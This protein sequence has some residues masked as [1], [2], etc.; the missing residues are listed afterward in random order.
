MIKR[1]YI[2]RKFY[3]NPNIDF[4]RLNKLCNGKNYLI[5]DPGIKNLCLCSPVE[6]KAWLFHFNNLLDLLKSEPLNNV[7]SLL[8]TQTD[9]NILCEDQVV[10]TNLTTQGFICGVVCS[11]MFIERMY[12]FAPKQK[13]TIAKHFFNFNYK[14]VRSNK[15]YMQLPASFREH[16]NTW[17]IYETNNDN[18]LVEKS[19][20]K[21]TELKKKDDLID[22]ILMSFNILET[23]FIASN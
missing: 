11:K 16:L 2:K 22:C 17:V 19:F 15:L 23:Q 13:Y 14:K 7:M 20:N 21:H 3:N 4:Q 6:K 1:K 5:I 8:S 9:L 12:S 10:K 18:C